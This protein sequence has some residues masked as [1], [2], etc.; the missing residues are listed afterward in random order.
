VFELPE[1]GNLQVEDLAAKIG[2]AKFMGQ[3]KDLNRLVL[4]AHQVP[5]YRIGMAEVGALGGSAA[6]EMLQVYNKGVIEPLQRTIEHRLESTLFG[7]DGIFL[8]D[9]DFHLFNLESAKEELD[10]A[11]ASS[12]VE[13]A[14]M[15]PNEGR[16]RLG[17]KPS[18][19]PEMDRFYWNG[20]SIDTDG[21]AASVLDA[22]GEIKSALRVALAVED[23]PAAEVVIDGSKIRDTAIT[24]EKIQ[25]AHEH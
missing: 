21:E 24:P 8:S 1:D 18:D 13:R 4:V 16:E 20:Q 5:P 17:L 23:A 7:P 10:L 12:C 2:D 25:H 19:D 6:R 9:W 22:V 15:S 11:I 14:L 3:R